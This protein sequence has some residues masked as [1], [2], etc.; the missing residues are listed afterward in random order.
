MKEEEITIIAI[1]IIIIKK[2][3][4]ILEITIINKIKMMLMMDFN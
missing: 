4:I 3:T 2:E 1:T